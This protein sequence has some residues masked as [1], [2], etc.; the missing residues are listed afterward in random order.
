MEFGDRASTNSITD[1]IAV[2]TRNGKE[3]RL[4]WSGGEKDYYDLPCDLSQ[5][6]S[7]LEN[8]NIQGKYLKFRWSGVTSGSSPVFEGLEFPEV[9]D[10]GVNNDL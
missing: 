8:F 9:D 2:F 4:E 6:V 3:S 1:K 10:Q 5:P 7:V